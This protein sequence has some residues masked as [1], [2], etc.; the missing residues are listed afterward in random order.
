MPFSGFADPEQLKILTSVLDDY[1][2]A[3][4]IEEWAPERAAAGRLILSLFEQGWQSHEELLG[5]LTTVRKS[6]AA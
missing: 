1:C 4:C 5:M 2:H 3:N 6:N